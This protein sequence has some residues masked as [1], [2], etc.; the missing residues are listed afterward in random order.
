MDRVNGKKVKTDIE[1]FKLNVDATNKVLPLS[2]SPVVFV[3]SVSFENNSCEDTI[4]Q[5]DLDSRNFDAIIPSEPLARDFIFQTVEKVNLPAYEKSSNI[6][7]KPYNNIDGVPFIELVSLLYEETVKWKKNLF[8]VMNK[9]YI[10]LLT[11]WL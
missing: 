9:I 4:P 6:I 7:D 5:R 8:Q 3:N 2:Q 1:N 11:E 10:K